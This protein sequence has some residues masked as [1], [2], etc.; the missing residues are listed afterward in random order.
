[1]K[2]TPKTQKQPIDYEKAVA[3][4]VSG[5]PQRDLTKDELSKLADMV[6]AYSQDMTG[7]ELYP[8]ELEFGWRIVYSLLC[9]D[10]EEIT[11]LFARQMGKCLAKGT[12]ILMFDGTVKPVEEVRV[13]DKLMGDD[14][15]ARNVLSIADGYGKLLTIS[16]DDSRYSR[17]TVNESHILTLFDVSENSVRDVHIQEVLGKEHLFRGIRSSNGLDKYCFSITKAGNGSYFGF[18]L[19]GNKRFLLEDGT[20]THNTET[21]AVTVC[22]LSVLLPILAKNLPHDERIKKF[23]RGVWIGIYAPNY[24]QAGIMWNRMKA[25]MYSKES[26]T[27]LL[28][29]DVDMDLTDVRE[30]MVLPNG[31]F[32]DCGT[33]SPQ[34]KIEGKTYHLIL[35]EESQDIPS[36]Q[37]RASIHPMAAACITGDSLIPLAN[38]RI[39]RLDDMPIKETGCFSE[40]LHFMRGTPIRKIDSGIQECLT[41]T[42]NSGKKITGTLDHPVI[43]K[44]RAYPRLPKWET[45]QNIKVGYQIAVPRAVPFF[46]TNSIGVEEA[47]VL[48]MLVGDGSYHKDCSPAFSGEDKEL[49]DFLGDWMVRQLGSCREERGH[50]TSARR[51]YKEVRCISSVEGSKKGKNPAINLLRAANIY[52]QTKDKKRVPSNI[53]EC[54]KEE[55]AAFLGGLYDTDGTIGV[56]ERK[57]TISLSQANRVILEEVSHLL[58]KFGIQSSIYEAISNGKGYAEKGSIYYKLD[59]SDK[60]SVLAFCKNIPLLVERKRNSIV[61]AEKVLEFRGNKRRAS[62]IVGSGSKR[63]AKEL[64]NDLVWERVV[65]IES[66]GKQQV[67]DIEM[68]DPAHNFIANNIVVHNTAGTLVKIGTCNRVRSDFYEACRRNKRA[69]VSDGSVRSRYRRHYE[70]DYTVGQKYNPRYRKY[71]LKEIER[72]GEDSDDFRLK[73]RLHWLLDR[74]MFVNP[75]LFDECGIKDKDNRLTIEIGKGKNK[76][77]VHFERAPN[78]VTYDNKTENIIAAIDVGRANSTVVTVGKAFWDSPIDVGGASRYPIHILNWLELHGDNHEAQHPQILEFLKNYQISQVVIDATG[79]GDPVYSRLAADLMEY[80]I[81]VEP[82]IFTAASKD[83]G[84]KVFSQEIS[85][86]RFTFPAGAQ[87][88]RLLKWQKFVNQMHDLEKEWRGQQMVVHKPKDGDNCYDDFPDSA[89]L[90]CWAINVQGTMEVEETDNPFIGRQ[91]RWTAASHMREAGALFR[92]VFEPKSRRPSRPGHN[93]RWD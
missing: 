23:E 68:P 62:I 44:P 6:M 35:L 93:G 70:Y 66:S 77:I 25:R 88:T 84:Y 53:W 61:I 42:L 10:A 92:K 30:N 46:G 75:E 69:D 28:D 43:W 21:V 2:D 24:L 78:V 16:P 50:T 67:Y 15:T 17:Y 40:T 57:V 13:G 5:I 71:I 89:M 87:A 8:Y 64:D 52:G 9:E 60:D 80:N 22:G 47:R 49:H 41:M 1:M 79:K 54:K 11:A 20:V 83:V 82:F 31:S 27:A 7:V 56:T 73:Y 3:D 19:D 55:V 14:S 72:L 76:K 37:I 12:P 32:V 48:G 33:A 36:S 90:L 18:V 63:Y 85:S 59:T 39:V 38:G 45:L 86:K 51:E 26:K 65:S 29:P 91:A 74:G 81:H 4:N 58:I 34:S